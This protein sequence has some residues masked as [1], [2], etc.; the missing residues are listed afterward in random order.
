[1]QQ[2]RDVTQDAV[3]SVFPLAALSISGCPPA[4][5]P[6]GHRMAA[7]AP[8]L[9]PRACSRPS[10]SKALR[11]RAPVSL[12]APKV[13]ADVWEPVP[14]PSCVDIGTLSLAPGARQRNSEGSTSW[15]YLPAWI[16]ERSALHRGHVRGAVRAA[17]PG[18]SRDCRLGFHTEHLPVTKFED[19]GFFLLKSWVSW[20]EPRRT[21]AVQ[22]R[23]VN[24]QEE[25]QHLVGAGPRQ[26]PVRPSLRSWWQSGGCRGG[27]FRGVLAG[28]TCT[29]Q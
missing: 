5:S 21:P 23:G 20:L 11:C 9:V 6:H 22:Y 26:G 15:R 19:K 29:W 16:Q 12:G 2:V 25:D 13:L 7:A 27:A 3:P 4:S 1:M 24:E 10:G 8:L 17:R 18:V 14:R 28:D